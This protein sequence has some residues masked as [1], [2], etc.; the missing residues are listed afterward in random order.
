MDFQ[1]NIPVTPFLNPQT[2][3]PTEAWHLYLL[4]LGA[5]TVTPPVTKAASTTPTALPV[6]TATTATTATPLPTP[7]APTFVNVY[8]GAVIP[9]FA[10]QCQMPSTGSVTQVALYFQEAAGLSSL[11]PTGWNLYGSVGSLTGTA[12]TPSENVNIEV[13]NANPTAPGM[14]YF[15]AFT[16]Q[17]ETQSA[18]S[19]IS[20]GF[21]WPPN[22]QFLVDPVNPVLFAAWDTNGNVTK[23]KVT[24]S[25]N[26]PLTTIPDG[27]AVMYSVFD[28]ANEVPILTDGGSDLTIGSATTPWTADASGSFPILAGSSIGEIVNT[29][30]I[31]PNDT[32]IPQISRFWAQ[33]GIS[34]WRKAT[35]STSTSFLFDPPFDVVPT[36]GETLN[37]VE[38][39]W[40]DDRGPDT[41]DTYGVPGESYRLACL[42]PGADLPITTPITNYEILSWESL[43]QV[44]SG[45]HITGCVRGLE[46]TVPLNAA[47]CNL[48]YYP[49]PGAG[50]TIIPIPVIAFVQSANGTWSAQVEIGIT[51]PTGYFASLS[52]CTFKSLLGKFIRS[53]IVPLTYGGAYS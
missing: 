14:Q 23:I 46:G 8:P 12:F 50:T 49:A 22:Y 27:L 19:G 41:A 39:A 4:S 30:L 1:N 37:W 17:N 34:Q 33:F 43:Q 38:I 6:I 10:V 5:K 20:V 42:I 21:T 29:T 44:G 28:V 16:I 9:K 15:V 11:N 7:N 51:V 3:M 25:F 36:T 52:C 32:D 35:G 40:Y 18:I 45:F 48:H 2:G 26:Q 31:T 53:D 24:C 47:G 13:L